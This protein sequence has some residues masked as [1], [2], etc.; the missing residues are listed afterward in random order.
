MARRRDLAHR[1]M[2][3]SIGILRDQDSSL[4]IA[5]LTVSGADAVMG[6]PLSGVSVAGRFTKLNDTGTILIKVH[7][8]FLMRYFHVFFLYF[9][10]F[11]FV[12]GLSF[13]E[14]QFSGS[15]IVLG[16]YICF[17]CFPLHWV[18]TLPPN[19][20]FTLNVNFIPFPSPS[21]HFCL[22]S[23]H[24]P[25]Q[26][27]SPRI[28]YVRERERRNVLRYGYYLLFWFIYGFLDLEFWVF[29]FFGG[30]FHMIMYL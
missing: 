17:P 23:T 26:V 7:Y 1:A 20:I 30:F 28:E 8:Y 29:F 11:L 25:L 22:F 6:T 27:F 14:R 21:C 10:R 9:A 5:I 16:Y 13:S 2:P 18:N 12:F 4:P 15:I 24:A 3:M 19:I